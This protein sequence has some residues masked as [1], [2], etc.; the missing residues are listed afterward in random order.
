MMFKPTLE[1]RRARRRQSLLDRLLFWVV[2]LLVLS[3]VLEIE[4]LIDE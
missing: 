3:G 2:A 4:K 1:Q